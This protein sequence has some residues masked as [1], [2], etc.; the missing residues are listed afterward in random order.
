MA[1]GSIDRYR[2]LK[3]SGTRS[4]S[5]LRVI[6]D[7]R[8]QHSQSTVNP[9]SSLPSPHRISIDV[10]SLP[11]KISNILRVEP[12]KAWKGSERGLVADVMCRS[13]SGTPRTN[14]AWNMQ[15][16]IPMVALRTFRSLS[17]P[18]VHPCMPRQQPKTG[19]ITRPCWT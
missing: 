18:S 19:Q 5:H 13:M 9:S 14:L 1:A 8:Y 3:T 4:H 6:S 12:W 10:C 15:I 7:P 11:G 17:T 2:H 16:R